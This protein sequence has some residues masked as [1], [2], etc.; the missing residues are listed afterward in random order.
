[1]SNVPSE[2]ARP[3]QTVLSV[4]AVQMA[5]QL[6]ETRPS[7]MMPSFLALAMF[8]PAKALVPLDPM[9]A[10]PIASVPERAPEPARAPGTSEAL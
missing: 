10:R 3:V 1:M 8:W 5:R 6:T 7:V 2:R 4:G 9:Y